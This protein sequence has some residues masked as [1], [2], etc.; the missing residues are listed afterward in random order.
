M[1][2]CDILRAVML[3]TLSSQLATCS[4][5][6]TSLSML[7]GAFACPNLHIRT[8]VDFNEAAQSRLSRI[9]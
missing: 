9:T 3:D 6:H 4:A 2:L 5:T 7:T 1:Y 8:V